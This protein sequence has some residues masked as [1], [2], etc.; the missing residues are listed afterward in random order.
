MS[1]VIPVVQRLIRSLLE[2]DSAGAQVDSTSSSGPTA[3]CSPLALLL[4]PSNDLCSQINA[5]L[6]KCCP[7]TAMI[8]HMHCVGASP[9]AS[10]AMVAASP[11]VVTCTPLVALELIRE[12]CLSIS[13]IQS[14]AIDEAD[15]IFLYGQSKQI[16]S[17]FQ[18]VPSTCQ[19]FV[20]SAT[21]HDSVRGLCTSIS[22]SSSRLVTV[23]PESMHQLMKEKGIISL[24]QLGVEASAGSTGPVRT[25]HLLWCTDDDERYLM[26]FGLLRLGVLRRRTIVFCNTMQVALRVHL[27]LDTFG[28]RAQLLNADLPLESR[29]QDVDKFNRGLVDTLVAVDSGSE[30]LGELKSLSSD[31]VTSLNIKNGAKK[32]RKEIGSILGV[33]DGSDSDDDGADDND[34]GAVACD[35]VNEMEDVSIGKAKGKAKGGAGGKSGG[36]FARGLDFVNVS[37]GMFH[38]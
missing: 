10:R 14:L 33:D 23:T 4:A 34:G 32:S 28:F 1:F 2:T 9:S 16:T 38:V 3:V 20:L 6:A 36:A 18:S 21:L 30:G 19:L 27:Y 5:V 31:D 37:Y 24:D 22:S 12:S 13:S 35:G 29:L 15:N 11:H 26:L 7:E 25:E 17:L 8:R